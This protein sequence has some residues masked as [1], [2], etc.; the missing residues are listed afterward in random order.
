MYAS[1]I[2]R[3]STGRN[4]EEQVVTEAEQVAAPVNMVELTLK[5]GGLAFTR[6]VPESAALQIMALAMGATVSPAVTAPAPPTVQ[7]TRVQQPAATGN[8]V[9]QPILNETV[10]EYISRHGAQ[11]NVE[12]IAA[13]AQFLKENGQDRISSDQVKEQ[14]PRAGEKVPGNYPRDFRWAIQ[15]KWIA[16]DHQNPK[17]Y[18]ITNTGSNAV[19]QQFSKDV[20]KA[21]QIKTSKRRGSAAAKNGDGDE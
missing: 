5:G 1:I 21:S 13:I 4:M 3:I 16:Q 9:Q 17:Q 15:S 7:P 14:F 20:R 10:G 18:Y 2:Q 6:E 19:A 8:R 12:K 11:R